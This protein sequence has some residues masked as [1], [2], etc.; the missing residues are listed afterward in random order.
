MPVLDDY[1]RAVAI[2]LIHVEEHGR[3]LSREKAGRLKEAF[4]W[5]Y[6]AFQQHAVEHG[7]SAGVPGLAPA[8]PPAGQ[9]APEGGETGTSQPSPAGV[10]V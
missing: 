2:S 7:L 6:E 1:E 4:P 10:P 5:W 8:Q 9:P 3:T